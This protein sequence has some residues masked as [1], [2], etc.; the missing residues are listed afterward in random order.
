MIA[1]QRTVSSSRDS[2]AGVEPAP[3][4]PMA[5]P[6]R[7][8]A[9]PPDSTD[10]AVIGAGVVGLA[11]AIELAERG[12]RVVVLEAGQAGRGASFG[13]AGWLTPSLALPLAQPGVACKALLWM[14]DPES[15][16]YIRPSLDPALLKWLFGFVMAGRA[17]RFYPG[18]RA[19]VELCLWSVDSWSALS[20]DGDD[21]FG[22]ARN[23]LLLVPE[24]VKGLSDAC[25]AATLVE[26][27][28]VRWESWEP[29]RVRFEEP[30]I[31]GS[32]PG[33]IFYPNDAHCEPDRAVAAL[34]QRAEQVGVLVCEHAPVIQ[35]DRKSDH[36]EALHT[37][38]GSLRAAEFVLAAGAWSSSV[39]RVLGINLPMRS[40]KGYALV[41]PRGLRH[42]RRPIYLVERKVTV[43]PHLSTLRLAGTLEIVGQDLCIN[44]RRVAAIA[45]NARAMLAI[46]PELADPEPWAGLR[47]CLPDGMPAIGRS[48]PVQNLWLATGHQMTGLKCSLGSARLLADLMTNRPPTFDPAPFDPARF[49]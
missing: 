11:C 1:T 8:P 22:F 4:F 29:E 24:S 3:P 2:G 33:A 18:A 13:N 34:R 21:D 26:K 6:H 40:A 43:T 41:Y 20:F 45:R 27:F 28:G 49:A 14:L 48:K 5:E 42:P 9:P 44:P 35:A 17:S 32:C 46:D 23:G 31:T 12:A 15:P 38:A 36:I 7:R 47:P 30:F 39:A 19:L 10:V 25:K 16:F 37:A